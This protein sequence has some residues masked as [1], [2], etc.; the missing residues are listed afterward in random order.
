MNQAYVHLIIAHLPVYGA[1]L[2]VFLLIH[3]IWS[4]SHP[5]ISAA[6]FLFICSAMGACIAYITG[7]GAEEKVEN[8]QGIA[9][10]SIE[11]HEEFALVALIAFI[12]LGLVSLIG[13]LIEF[14]KSSVSRNWALA[15]LFISI[16]SFVIVARTSNLGGHIRHTEIGTITTVNQ[17]QED[18]GEKDD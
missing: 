18:G 5:F 8:L 13:L 3:G 6:Y 4:K 7:E 11:Q 2:G 10:N 16:A 9:S 17:E 14:K 15:M 1:I 12:L